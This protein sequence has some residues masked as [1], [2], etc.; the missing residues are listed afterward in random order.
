MKK[1]FVCFAVFTALIFMISCGDI[2]EVNVG[3]INVGTGTNDQGNSDSG[4]SDKKQGELYGECYPNKTCDE[5]LACEEESNTCI[6]KTGSS[7]N[8][9]EDQAAPEQNDNDADTVSEQNDGDSDNDTDS[10]ESTS[11]EDA[12]TPSEQTD[13]DEDTSDTSASD[14][15]QD[16]DS[17][18]ST[19]DD[20]VDTSD[21]GDD[22]DTIVPNCSMTSGT[23]CRDPETDLIWS[24]KFQ[25]VLTWDEAVEYCKGLDGGDKGWRLPNV[26]EL[27]T[28]I[29][30][31]HTNG[32]ITGICPI[33]ESDNKLASNDRS[34]YC[35]RLER[36]KDNNC[37]SSLA[38]TFWNSPLDFG[39]YATN[40]FNDHDTSLP[41]W[42]IQFWSSSVVLDILIYAW[43]VQFSLFERSG[44]TS[45]S[46]TD[47]NYQKKSSTAYVRCVRGE[48]N[49]S[50]KKCKGGDGVWNEEKNLCQR[51]F[52]CTTQN[53]SNWNGQCYFEQEYVSGEWTGDVQSQYGEE[54]GVCRFTCIENYFWDGSECVTPCKEDSCTALA[55]SFCSAESLTRFN[56]VCRENYSFEDN[57]C[58]ADT[59]E[60]PCD[61][62]IE[63]AQY[64]SASSIKQTWNGSTWEPPLTGS[65][66]ITPSD[67]ECRFKCKDGYSWTGGKCLKFP[68]TDLETGLIWSSKYQTPRSEAAS[69]C[70]ELTEGG[71]YDWHLANID[72]LRTLIKDR[73][74]ATGGACMVSEV[75]HC[76]SESCWSRESCAEAC[77]NNYYCTEYQDGRYSTLGDSES[78]VS[79]SAVGDGNVWFVIFSTGAIKHYSFST[80]NFR[81]VR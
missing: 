34:D 51:N 13:D 68:Y 73:K 48:M 67:A 33:S 50:S 53:N 19:P 22:S 46:T 26:D 28:L 15:D 27:R 77:S 1:L 56:C 3:D 42:T 64:N 58:V 60:E 66:N 62:L 39:Y 71:Y 52:L 29:V 2:G 36:V 49:E 18:D 6:K 59:R 25:S 74:T 47:I 57:Q 16:T 75:N 41:Q 8:N 14:N 43:Y 80:V 54:S 38:D 23:P 5:G 76:L 30:N 20:D 69:Y 45:T 31:Y 65:Y 61:D 44:W 37:L 10:G 9:D 17:E 78:L 81:C 35:T 63:N 70:E 21:S 4:T 79:S 32:E 7:E 72:E 24:E 40:K 12:D 55:H 11:D